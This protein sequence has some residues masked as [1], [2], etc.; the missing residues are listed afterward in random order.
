VP[1]D[2]EFDEFTQALSRL[3]SPQL[4]R[5][6]KANWDYEAAEPEI[7]IQ[8]EIAPLGYFARPPASSYHQFQ[9]CRQHASHCPV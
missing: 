9:E 2:H 1:R 8:L 5:Q 7:R 6:A 3:N 4:Q